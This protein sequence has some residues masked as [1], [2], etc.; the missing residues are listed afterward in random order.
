MFTLR[1]LAVS[2][3]AFLWEMLYY[4]IYVPAGQPMPPRE[5]LGEPEVARYVRDWGRPGDF[6]VV[7]SGEDEDLI[8]AT[9]LRLWVGNDKGYGYVEDGIPELSIAILPA[10]RGRG[11]GTQMLKVALEMARETYPGVSLSVV[12][13]N[14]AKRLYERFGFRAVEQ[15]GDSIKMVLRW[16]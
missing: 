16:K 4:A 5:I 9:W 10:Y 8:G 1:P 6:G 2:D 14:P 13:Q 7:V 12:E 3:K 15:E 11:L